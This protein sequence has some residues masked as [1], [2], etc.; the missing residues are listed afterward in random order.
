[1]NSKAEDL[2]D[3]FEDVQEEIGTKDTDND[4]LYDVVEENLYW[5][6][7]VHLSATNKPSDIDLFLG[8]ESDNPN[9]FYKYLKDGELVR[10]VIQIADD[11]Y[12]AKLLDGV[13][14]DI[15]AYQNK[16]I[17][18]YSEICALLGDDIASNNIGEDSAIAHHIL[19]Y[20]SD[21]QKY[22]CEYCDYEIIA[23][24]AEDN[25]ALIT[26]DDKYFIYALNTMIER[27]NNVSEKQMFRAAESAIRERIF[28]MNS[29][30]VYSSYD[31]YKHYVD[32]NLCTVGYNAKNLK[33][34]YLSVSLSENSYGDTFSGA[35]GSYSFD[36]KDF[37]EDLYPAIITY[38]EEISGVVTG[39]VISENIS[40]KITQDVLSELSSKFVEERITAQKYESATDIYSDMLKDIIISKF[41]EAGIG[42]YAD[43]VTAIG[44]CA[45]A[46]HIFV[47]KRIQHFLQCST[48]LPG[49]YEINI[50][51]QVNEQNG[52]EN[53]P[54][55]R[56]TFISQMNNTYGINYLNELH[57]VPEEDNLN[58]ISNNITFNSSRYLD[59]PGAFRV[60]L[61]GNSGQSYSMINNGTTKFT[62][63]NY[64]N[65][66]NIVTA[67][68]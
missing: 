52:D 66:R 13:I 61:N 19:S 33:D 20:H 68:R 7:G 1:M 54:Y 6:N 9:T 65:L 14:W 4:G 12:E 29:N 10:E 8:F 43:L 60:I 58:Y 47:L 3:N 31:N 46:H 37:E 49:N 62:F 35:I 21:A 22:C 36:K 53:Y 38:I 55:T 64:N 18:Q 57:I 15:P 59:E 16:L 48:I 42:E 5:F 50:E 25:S 41:I 45:L 34:Y 11:R 56:Y 51:Y 32:P 63:E 23:P 27:D 30:Y 39:K 17:E 2:M 24:E 67:Q 26:N 28:E 44:K 40:S